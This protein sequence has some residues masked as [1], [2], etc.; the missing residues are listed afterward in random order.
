MGTLL[1]ANGA[2]KLKDSDQICRLISIFA[3]PS[4][5][6]RAVCQLVLAQCDNSPG[7]DTLKD[8][9]SL[10]WDEPRLLK[11][12]EMNECKADILTCITD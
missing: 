11:F 5:C 2:R 9:H 4:I 3:Y 7:K 10:P 12:L 8:R 1:V 6:I